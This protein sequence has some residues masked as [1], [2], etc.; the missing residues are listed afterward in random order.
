MYRVD[1][2][3]NATI[4]GTGFGTGVTLNDMVFGSCGQLY[5]TRN[6]TDDVLVVMGPGCPCA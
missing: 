6:A 3:G 1:A 4:V 2:R 5:I